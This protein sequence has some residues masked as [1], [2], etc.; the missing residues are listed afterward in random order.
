MIRACVML[1][2]IMTMAACTL[3]PKPQPTITHDP[4]RTLCGAVG[5]MTWRQAD[6]D[7]TKKNIKVHNANRRALCPP[8][9]YPEWYY[10]EAATAAL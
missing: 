7:E 10:G 2:V 9:R 5:L 4:V 6:T 1:A 3:F 8:D